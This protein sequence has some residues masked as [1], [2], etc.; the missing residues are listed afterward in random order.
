MIQIAIHFHSYRF[1]HTPSSKT[2]YLSRRYWRG[3]EI[4]IYIYI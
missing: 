4:Y 3:G 2:S 1:C